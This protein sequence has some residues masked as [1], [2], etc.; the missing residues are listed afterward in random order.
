MDFTGTVPGGFSP[1]E[2]YEYDKMVRICGVFSS[3]LYL[4]DTAGTVLLLHDSRYGLLPFGIGVAD[5][6]GVL[7][8][9]SPS[10]GESVHW[11]KGKLYFANGTVLSLEERHLPERTRGKGFSDREVQEAIHHLAS[12]RRGEVGELVT[13]AAPPEAFES[14]FARKAYSSVALLEQGLRHCDEET[15][16]RGLKGLIGLGPG[17]TPSMDDF[18]TGAMYTF[19]YGEE[20]WGRKLPGAKLL[21]EAVLEMPANATGK[22]SRAYLNAGARGQRFSILDGVLDGFSPEAVAALLAVGGHSGG[23]MMTG[24][25]WAVKCL[26]M[27]QQ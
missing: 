5:I 24:I 16:R 4:E 2:E 1:A 15:I 25:L 3:A 10:V 19:H 8:K 12:S 23:D 9:I 21:Y 20:C 22:Y 6:H 17:L 26:K 7:E 27:F 13:S 18:L 14:L 11:R